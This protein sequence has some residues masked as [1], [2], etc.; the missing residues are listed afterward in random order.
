MAEEALE[1]L[2]QQPGRVVPLLKR[3]I[4]VLGR[5]ALQQ[6]SLENIVALQDPPTLIQHREQMMRAVDVAR[7]HHDNVTQL[8]HVVA[9]AP[10]LALVE[11]GELAAEMLA[12]G[13]QAL[14]RQALCLGR[15][16]GTGAARLHVVFEE[17]TLLCTQLDAV[18]HAVQ[19][20]R[21][22]IC[23]NQL[24]KS[25]APAP[26]PSLGSKIAQHGCQNRERHQPLLSVDDL[27]QARLALASFWKV[28]AALVNQDY[29][30]QEV[31]G[32]HRRRVA[33]DAGSCQHVVQKLSG[34]RSGPGVRPLVMGNRKVER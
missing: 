8:A 28:A 23:R 18:S 1:A 21:S 7:E 10:A 2:S 4:E 15:C 29:G 31:V 5:R 11:H 34:L 20:R 33:S 9:E 3:G 19:S 16:G 24:I 6:L 30:A 13:Q 26:A 25:V 14:L 17:V 27:E 22:R 32:L 12:H